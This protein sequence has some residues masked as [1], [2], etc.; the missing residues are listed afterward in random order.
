[1]LTIS[2]CAN[3]LGSMLYGF[4]F[5]AAEGKEFAVVWFAG[6][7]SLL[8]A[9]GAKNIFKKLSQTAG[10]TPGEQPIY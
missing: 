7:A 3:P 4:L 9:I 5:E 1:M 2:M 6:A 10:G 8:I